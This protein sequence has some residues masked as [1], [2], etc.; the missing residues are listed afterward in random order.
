[1]SFLDRK[2]YTAGQGFNRWLVPPAALAVHISIGQIYAYSV[3]NKPLVEA[4]G[5][6]WSL[7]TVGWI[8]SIALAVL[9]A[10]AALFGKWLER[11]GPRMGMVLSACCFGL[12]FLVSALGIH[13]GSI[14]LVYLGNGVIGGVGL[15]LG[16]ISPVSTL[17][18]WFPDR[19]GM[20]TGL[21]IMGFGGGAMLASPLS[22]ALLNAVGIEST[23]IILGVFYFILIVFG[24]LIV[25]V[26][27][28]DWQPKGF[29]KKA[30]KHAVTHAVTASQAIKTPQFYFLF[31]VLCLNVTAGIGV[32]GQASVMIQEMFS[33][34]SV[35]EQLAVN[36]AAAAGFV[37]LLSLFNMGGRFIW[38]SVSDVIGRKNT[39]TVF[40]VLGAILYCLVPS[41][42]QNGQLVGFIVCFCVILSMYG[43]GF[44]AMPAYLR[45]LFGSF[46]VG[47]IH[48]RVLLAW[49]AAAV[50][51]PV[52][53]NYIRQAQIAS[54]VPAADAYS[55][56]M[57]IMAG[58]LLLG[59]LCNLLIKPVADKHHHNSET[60][61]DDAKS[62]IHEVGELITKS[63]PLLGMFS[64]ALVLALML[65]GVF[66]VVLK[67]L[68]LFTA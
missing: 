17:M 47:A 6:Q 28:P 64:W 21:A 22:V 25:K 30:D 9:G 42:G 41:L 61:L 62:A 11:V 8:F 3:F 2:S 31:C 63:H 36:V 20:A 27:A 55:I 37:G 45:D 7:A 48:G 43:G 12:G 50:L 23:Y 18:K 56:T 67:V 44:A 24:A 46:E 49:S 5:G 60:T 10:S 39:Y 14:W 33:V 1:M 59:L 29:H 4:S 35:G 53:V 40:F 54:G 66:M 26:P 38:S 51:G 34:Q 19:P 57:Y 13:L 65:Y 15:G 68:Q 16:Y 52:L 58:L 32:L